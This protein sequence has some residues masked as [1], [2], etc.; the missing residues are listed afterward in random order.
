MADMLGGREGER[1]SVPHSHVGER[2]SILGDV[3]GVREY[4]GPKP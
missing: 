3:K 2:R 4:S 1:R